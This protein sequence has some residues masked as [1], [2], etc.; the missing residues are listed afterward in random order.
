MFGLFSRKRRAPPPQGMSLEA[1]LETLSRFGIT[2]NRGITIDD[3]LFSF[4]RPDYEMQPFHLVLS[5]LGAEVERAPWGRAFSDRVWNFDTECIGGTGDYS[6]IVKRLSRL[7]GD[8]AHLSDVEDHVDIA[9]G[10]G[11][12]AYTVDGTRRDLRAKIDS[13]WADTGVVA[14]IMDDLER[15]GHRF[16]VKDR[17][18]AMLLFYLTDAAAGEINTLMGGGLRPVNAA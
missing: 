18:Q 6:A 3:L 11:R 10:E 15:D 17:G 5:T 9:A 13:D 2:L 12:V 8:P 14:R 7:S 1:Q 4:S 16:Y